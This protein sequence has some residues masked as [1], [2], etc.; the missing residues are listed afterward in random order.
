[1]WL[2]RRPLILLRPH[3]SLRRFSTNGDDAAS[4]PAPT[5]A[6]AASGGREF[7]KRLTQNAKGMSAQEI[8]TLFATLKPQLLALAHATTFR[9]E[10]DRFV[11]DEAAEQ[12]RWDNCGSIAIALNLMGKYGVRDMDIVNALER[13]LLEAFWC[14]GSSQRP[15]LFTEQD[16]SIVANAY[17]KLSVRSMKLFAAMEHAMRQN[18][19]TF[20]GELSPQ[21]CSLVLNAYAKLEVP[22][23]RDVVVIV[24][25]H[26]RRLM[27]GGAAFIP[28]HVAIVLNAYAKL[29]VPAGV[30]GD[31]AE[32]AARRVVQSVDAYSQQS[33]SMVLHAFAKF[34]W[35]NQELL[36]CACGRLRRENGDLATLPEQ[37]YCMML[38]ALSRLLY[39][40]EALLAR[41]V[42]MVPQMLE[43][44]T[45]QGLANSF[46]SFCRLDVPAPPDETIDLLSS[47][48]LRR[49]L[50]PHTPLGPFEHIHLLNC[51]FAAVYFMRNEGRW[52]D[53]LL[54]G[55][56][57]GVAERLGA[58][59]CDSDSR[60][61]L[62]K[63]GLTT[64][65]LFQ[66]ITS[67]LHLTLE[68]SPCRSL[69]DLS[70]S[71]IGTWVW[72]LDEIGPSL[73]RH[74]DGSEPLDDSQGPS[75]KMHED[76][77]LSL[78]RA[79]VGEELMVVEEAEAMPFRID[80]VVMRMNR[81]A[82][83]W[84]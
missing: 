78:R 81:G 8:R 63:C 36:E 71:S 82:T 58:R 50:A 16:L 24:G 38:Y 31:V 68:P 59:G 29:Q 61:G 57:K 23:A 39:R 52:F 4:P 45:P 30:F 32:C 42:D 51:C 70:L 43:G 48:C 34:E 79:T 25:A 15:S 72:L 64:E 67:L 77:S 20:V 35:L 12:D 60:S 6:S 18:G 3:R 46:L 9:Q 14:D 11:C 73:A 22:M 76:V 65:G 28:Q 44:F 74:A 83:K 84:A 5:S 37:H 40:D 1:M 69:A 26:V 33:L 75:S 27:E 62:Q 56:V 7:I 10:A 19:G 17:A 66:L 47:E 49:A 54:G 55:M 41:L 21:G 80:V 53:A 2:A 13:P